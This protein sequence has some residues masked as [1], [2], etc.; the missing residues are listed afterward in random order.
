MRWNCQVFWRHTLKW[1]IYESACCCE[2]PSRILHQ[3]CRPLFFC[4]VCV[5]SSAHPSQSVLLL[6]PSSL[7]APQQWYVRLSTSHVVLCWGL[8]GSSMLPVSASLLSVKSRE[9]EC[10]EEEG[11]HIAA[12]AEPRCKCK[13]GLHQ[14]FCC[15]VNTCMSVGGCWTVLAECKHLCW[16]VQT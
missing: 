10:S 2:D 13:S 1:F 8:P 16:C 4:I 7:C 3:N 15:R 9:K 5:I 14:S 6:L 12:A 11:D